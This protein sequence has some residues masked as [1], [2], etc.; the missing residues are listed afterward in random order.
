MHLAEYQ[1]SALVWEEAPSS[2]SSLGVAPIPDGRVW[3]VTIIQAGFSKNQRFYP[4]DVLARAAHLFEDAPVYVFERRD[5]A[6][7][8]FDHL[9]PGE[10]WSNPQGFVKNLVG[11]VRGARLVDESLKAQLHLFSDARWLR[12]KLTSMLAEGALQLIGLSIDADGEVDATGR[13][14]AISRV[15]SVDLVTHPAAGGAIE[16]LIASKGAR[17]PSPP[18]VGAAAPP[19]PSPR[20]ARLSGRSNDQ[21]SQGGPR[22]MEDVTLNQPVRVSTAQETPAVL[23]T[24]ATVED[25]LATAL[26]E[27]Q[28]ARCGALLERKLAESR[29]PAP[30]L[31]VI[32]AHFGGAVFS[33]ATLDR[34]LA[35]HRTALAEALESE[36]SAGVVRGCGATKVRLTADE[37]DKLRRRLDG[38]FANRDL[39]GVP[40]F[41][42]F[43]EAYVTMTGDA[44]VTGHLRELRRLHESLGSSDWAEI[45]G[46]SISRQMVAEYN[47]PGLQ[48]WRKIVSDVV[49]INDFR[50][51]RRMRFGGYGTLPSVAQAQ[52]YPA[53]TSPADEEVTYSASKYGGTEEITLE[54]IKNDDVGAI[55]RI[56]QRL[57][58]A[59]A[60]TLYRFVFDFIRTNSAIYDGV[61]LFHAS[62]TNTGASAL[63]A[64]SLNAAMVA[65]A[66]QASYGNAGELLNIQ[67]RYLLAPNELRK[68]AWQLNHSVLEVGTSQNEA[69]LF[70][71]LGLEVV[72]VPYWTDADNW[73]LVADP[74]D[75]PTI[76]IGFLD[77]QEEPELF[78]QDQPNAGSVFS[79]DKITYKV[80]HIYGGVVL[81][82]RGFYGAL[83]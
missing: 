51:Q 66:D 22:A 39:E 47:V 4:R 63:S 41:K 77:G 30:L 11:V 68:L 49:P 19:L 48:D 38:F 27:V 33:E 21:P 26:R 45:L 32:R 8:V 3:E 54:M 64:T 18:G 10:A 23:L 28:V 42:S 82:Y 40:R 12:E 20:P 16:R 7:E 69:N 61:A 70:S 31:G 37:G 57:A 13:V 35:Q 53:L 71:T 29:L 24:E 62:H 80:R 67:P 65:L 83:V 5:G 60:Q 78:V 75:V 36:Q 43:K 50:T 9:P 1:T 6:G 59:A 2:A 74:I 15:H 58:R 76:E 52:A 55:R 72:V 25:R 56:P 81:D 14:V 44:T 17:H 73:Y 46:D 34:A 79:N